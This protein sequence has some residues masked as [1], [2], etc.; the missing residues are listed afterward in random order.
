MRLF[1]CETQLLALDIE[2]SVISHNARQEKSVLN[3]NPQ[4]FHSH[5]LKPKT[6]H[7][8]F[9]GCKL[10]VVRFTISHA[11]PIVRKCY[12]DCEH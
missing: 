8:A 5:E 12:G 10:V 7:S 3:R 6:F 9:V 4:C 2:E 1:R 11:R